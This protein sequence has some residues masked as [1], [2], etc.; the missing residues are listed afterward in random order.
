MPE[1][2]L[3]NELLKIMDENLSIELVEIPHGNYEEIVGK[4]KTV[5]KIL[6]FL[7]KRKENNWHD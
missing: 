1:F 2:T 5:R 6:E 3:E 4:E 7:Y